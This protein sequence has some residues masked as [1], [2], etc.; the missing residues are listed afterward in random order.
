MKWPN[1]A[2]SGE[3]ERQDRPIRLLLDEHSLTS[4]VRLAEQT[5]MPPVWEGAPSTGRSL[6]GGPRLSTPPRALACR[7]APPRAPS[8]ARPSSP[9]SG[10]CGGETRAC[11]RRP[12]RASPRHPTTCARLPRCSTSRTARAPGPMQRKAR[13]SSSPLTPRHRASAPLHPRTPPCEPRRRCARARPGAAA[14][15]RGHRWR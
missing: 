1:T 7:G 4:S 11:A 6:H 10:C 5:R 13:A 2:D 9:W 15:W 12:R 8:A 14:A 3:R